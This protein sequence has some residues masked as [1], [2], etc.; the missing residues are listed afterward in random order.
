MADR[1]NVNPTPRQEFQSNPQ[2]I[3]MHRDMIQQPMLGVSIQ[4]SLMQYQRQM[5]DARGG[6]GNSA[7]TSFFK[8][9]G[10]IEFLDIFKKLGEMAEPLKTTPNPSKIDFKAL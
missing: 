3:T 7:A 8:M 5:C 2:F 1:P 6:D 9:Q 10:V 4:Y